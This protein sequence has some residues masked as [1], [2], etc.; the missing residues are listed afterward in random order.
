METEPSPVVKVDRV[1]R[2]WFAADK[3]SL[4]LPAVHIVSQGDCP[5]HTTHDELHS[6]ANPL[7]YLWSIEFLR[8]ELL[9][10]V[11][12]KQ[13]QT[14]FEFVPIVAVMHGVSLLSD[15]M[16]TL[17]QKAK[18]T[19]LDASTSGETLTGS[20]HVGVTYRVSSD[21]EAMFASHMSLFKQKM[22]NGPLSSHKGA[23]WANTNM[24]AVKRFP[25]YKQLDAWFAST[26]HPDLVKPLLTYVLDK[27][28]SSVQKVIICPPSLPFGLGPYQTPESRLGLWNA[29]LHLEAGLQIFPSADGTFTHLHNVRPTGSPLFKDVAVGENSFE[30]ARVLWNTCL[31]PKTLA[32]CVFRTAVLAEGE[33]EAALKQLGLSTLALSCESEDEEEDDLGKEGAGRHKSAAI[34][35]PLVVTLRRSHVKTSQ[36]GMIDCS[37]WILRDNADI[38]IMMWQPGVLL[39]RTSHVYVPDTSFSK[40]R[41]TSLCIYVH[42]METDDKKPI[43]LLEIPQVRYELHQW[44]LKRQK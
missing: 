5:T 38:C 13:V 9:R 24:S 28:G 7:G 2:S 1:L 31:S 29:T 16:A 25:C 27:T 12:E 4:P 30:N 23:D 39:P 26:G 34:A 35:C 10:C 22:V 44:L 40:Q 41:Q 15:T 42:N 17:K 37:R 36:K 43:R 19:E 8:Q 21:E 32:R 20:F 33:P 6:I 18:A 14:Y 3:T 11:D